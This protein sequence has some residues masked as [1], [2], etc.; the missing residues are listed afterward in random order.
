MGACPMQIHVWRIAAAAGRHGEL[1]PDPAC[2]LAAIRWRDVICCACYR[3]PMWQGACALF[4]QPTA[5]AAVDRGALQRAK[6]LP[7]SGKRCW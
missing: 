4:D 3:T 2:R 6:Q 5:D 7:G 1:G